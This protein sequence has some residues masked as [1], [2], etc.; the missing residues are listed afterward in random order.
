MPHD[1]CQSPSE[2]IEVLLEFKASLKHTDTNQGTA[3]NLGS[4]NSNS[5]QGGLVNSSVNPRLTFAPNEYEN[6]PKPIKKEIKN[7]NVSH[8]TCQ[9][10]TAQKRKG[11]STTY[12]GK[13]GPLCAK[14]PI[15]MDSA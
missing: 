9:K 2:G 11:K 12:E 1:T 3:P 13:P 15:P 14:C 5:N 4:E 10:S 6:M 7:N 8:D